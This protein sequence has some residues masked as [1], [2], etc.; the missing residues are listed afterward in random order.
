MK[1]TISAE[2]L[3]KVLEKAASEYEYSVREY[4][5]W[6]NAYEARMAENDYESSDGC[7][8]CRDIQTGI[9]QGIRMILGEMGY[10]II[11]EH[12]DDGEAVYKT[13]QRI[14]R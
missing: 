14:Q 8:S 6:D 9:M 11:C 13:V 12:T 10:S 5:Y 2:T 4:R 7:A 3:E 1:N